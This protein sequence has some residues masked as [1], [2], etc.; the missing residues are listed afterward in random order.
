MIIKKR[1]RRV[2]R[3]EAERL[4]ILRGLLEHRVFHGIWL[5]GHSTTL[6]FARRFLW[7][8]PFLVPWG[9]AE[10][11]VA[12]AEAARSAKKPPSRATGAAGKAGRRKSNG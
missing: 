1:L 6:L 7:E 9:E 8:E 11:L 4:V 5:K 12:Q 10:E 3:N 2:H